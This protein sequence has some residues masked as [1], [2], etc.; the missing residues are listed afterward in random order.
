MEKRVLWYKHL[1]LRGLSTFLKVVTV[2]S[3]KMLILFAFF[4][5]RSFNVFGTGEFTLTPAWWIYEKTVQQFVLQDV[6]Y[7]ELTEGPEAKKMLHDLQAQG[8]VEEYSQP[9]VGIEMPYYRVKFAVNEAKAKRT[10]AIM[11][12]NNLIAWVEWVPLF[13]I[14]QAFIYGSEQI[15]KDSP[16]K[17]RKQLNAKPIRFTTQQVQK[18]DFE[19]QWYVD[20]I[21]LVKE[22]LVCMPPRKNEKVKVAIIDNAFMS[23][24][25]SFS[26]SVVSVLDVADG[27]N[28]V[29]PP[30]TNEN[31]MHG[32]HSA[33]LIVGKKFAW[34]WIVGTSLGSAELYLLKATSDLALPNEI[35]HGV[36]AFAKA[37]ELDVDIISLSWWAYMDFPIFKRVVQKAL[38]KWIVVIA[39]AGNYGSDD[40]FYPAAYEQVISVGSFD[41]SFRRSSFSNYGSW[42]DIYAPGEELVVPDRIDW[43]AKT[44][45][46]SAAA[47]L[48]AWV[49]AFLL[50][51]FGSWVPL[52]SYYLHSMNE[53]NYLKLH[54]LCLPKTEP[55]PEEELTL[56]WVTQQFDGWV[57]QE[58]PDFD[59]PVY[60]HPIAPTVQQVPVLVP[61][62]YTQIVAL[63]RLWWPWMLASALFVIWFILIVMK[64]SSH[65]EGE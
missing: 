64:K 53:M 32:T 12:S 13:M 16:P 46:T 41:T 19:W 35:T 22:E 37:V 40:L 47:P 27:D 28:D 57:P 61:D 18:D 21:G 1:Q 49:Y 44:D 29:V 63:I 10:I 50:H 39:A 5:N 56:T 42:V 17:Q 30:F 7:L 25:P 20:D 2:I 52:E 36:E 60:E 58:E 59:L 45:G 65:N 26:G 4:P 43:F 23:R 34:K 62:R 3:C 14:Q 33:G 38:D 24:H 51:S 8:V 6:Y 55:E 31:R 54:N 11:M 48:F 9:F 15:Q